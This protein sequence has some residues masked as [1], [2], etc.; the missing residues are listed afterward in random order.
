MN[1]T[2]E[3]LLKVAYEQYPDGIDF[4]FN[5]SIELAGTEY[6]SKMASIMDDAV[7]QVN[8]LTKQA[9]FADALKNHGK[10]VAKGVGTAALT[11]VAISML[12]DL[13]Q[14]AH[15][16]VTR[17]RNFK[18]MLE[19]APDL[20]QR[21]DQ[22]AIRGI[23]DSLH[24]LAGPKVSGEP[25]VAAEFVKTQIEYV[26]GAGGFSNAKNI[27]DLV[28]ARNNIERSGQRI[29]A[30]SFTS[31][32]SRDERKEYNETNQLKGTQTSTSNSKQT[33]V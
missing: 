17:N 10:D 15:E 4:I 14:N 23:F 7:A 11:G 16:S 27:S 12:N 19:Y 28:G 22:K 3:D 5:S 32:K 26:G 18:K 24:T 1:I 9:G 30:P 21:E 2:K 33:R 6:I 31:T 13:V 20:K 29:V 8:S 25:H